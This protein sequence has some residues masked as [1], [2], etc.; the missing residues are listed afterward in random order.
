MAAGS[1][2]E[3]VTACEHADVLIIGAGLSGIGAAYYLQKF[4]PAK[5]YLILEGR[6][7]IGGTWDL[8]RYPGVRSDSDMYTFGYSFRPWTGGQSFADGDS[9]RAYI[10]ETAEA[11]GIDRKIRF[12]HRVVRA[13][14][15]SEEACWTVDVEFGT[16]KQLRR[17][18]CGFLYACT[19]YYDYEQGH[20]PSWP[21][22]ERFRGRIIH[23]QQWP[24]GLDYTDRRVV[25]VGS[26]AT[27]VTLVPAM[28]EKA[29]HVTML[30]R[31]PTY[32][33]SRP[34]HDALAERLQRVLPERAA[35]GITR[36]KNVLQSMLYYRIARRRPELFRKSVMESAQ[37]ALGPE[38]DVG[39]HFNPDYDP[40]DQ[41]L[42]LAPD[43][44]L[45]STLRSGHA[46]I[47]TDR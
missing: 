43:G 18:T 47:V 24:E 35:Y 1:A 27:A 36:W 9:I 41:R 7:A 28:A 38:I 19:G 22:M 31:S 44:N 33:A 17:F 26:G 6:G 42:C 32:V 12:H 46:S 2:R 8:F 13:S 4:H 34:S 14:W 37:K 23:P 40:W 10:R 21:G 29:G 11:Y 30:Q 45:F 20:A 39:T 5:S 3:C 16:E 25:V 15:S